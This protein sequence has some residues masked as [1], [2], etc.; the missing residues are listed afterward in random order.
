MSFTS[1]NAYVPPVTKQA[2]GEARQLTAAG[3]W[4]W[5]SG[6]GGG[7]FT[8]TDKLR[9]SHGDVL[10]MAPLVTHETNLAEAGTVKR[11][12][13]FND[14][15]TLTPVTEQ[16]STTKMDIIENQGLPF[17]FKDLRDDTYVIY[18]AYIDS[19]TENIAPSW[20]STTYVGRSEPV[21]NYESTL[22]DIS[23]NLKLYAQNVSELE[24]IYTKMNRLTSMCYPQYYPDDD[25]LS[26]N[27]AQIRQKSPLTRLRIGDIFGGSGGDSNMMLGFLKSITYTVPPEATWEIAKDKKVPKYVT[28]AISY[29]VIHETVPSYLTQFY[30]KQTTISD[31]DGMRGGF[32]EAVPS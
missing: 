18:R 31:Q 7:F 9:N 2:K 4:S 21:F 26:N 22:R 12:P 5:I 16:A 11:V 29:Q 6:L 27:I 30:G 1:N 19:L 13:A 14:D 10:T 32:A 8:S 20:K 25:A 3:A 15:G 23:F 24:M 17:Y 28:A